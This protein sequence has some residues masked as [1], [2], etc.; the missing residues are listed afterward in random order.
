MIITGQTRP[1]GV[2]TLMTSYTDNKY[3]RF[4]KKLYDRGNKTFDVVHPELVRL[5]RETTRRDVPTPVK[6]F[7]YY[8]DCGVGYW[9]IG[10]NSAAISQKMVRPFPDKELFVCGEHYSANN[11]Q[12]ME[13]ALETSEAV[14][15]IL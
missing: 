3:A 8:W 13:G 10:A 14:V 15:E 6:S 11:Q 12:W 2:T 7:F 9:G 1:D 4:W 5:L